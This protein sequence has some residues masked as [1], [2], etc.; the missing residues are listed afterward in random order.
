MRAACQGVEG[1]E[2]SPSQGAWTHGSP[3][4]GHRWPPRALQ[5]HTRRLS[6]PPQVQADSA[7]ALQSPGREEAGDHRELRESLGRTSH[8]SWTCLS[9]VVATSH[10][11]VHS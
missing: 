1:M 8:F 6:S 5:G 10:V 9:V 7:C 4:A 11:S 3:L 2:G